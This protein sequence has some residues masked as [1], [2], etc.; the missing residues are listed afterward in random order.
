M[1]TRGLGIVLCS[2]LSSAAI[3]RDQQTG[4]G[5]SGASAISACHALKVLERGDREK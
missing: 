4:T 2:L 1:L 3:G 5:S